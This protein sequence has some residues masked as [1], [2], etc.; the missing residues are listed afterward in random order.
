MDLYNKERACSKCGETE[1]VN[2]FMK[3]ID[4]PHLMNNTPII[5]EEILHKI[6]RICL[7]CEYMW[8]EEPLDK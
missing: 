2:H 8:Y 5:V 7:N 1:T 3:I 6:R 4:V